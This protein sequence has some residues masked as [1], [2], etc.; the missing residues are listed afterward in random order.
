MS[1]KDK[2]SIPLFKTYQKKIVQN[3]HPAP[4]ILPVHINPGNKDTKNEPPNQIK[5]K[6]YKQLPDISGI[7]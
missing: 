6:Q 7:L 1:R 2:N 5:N 4:V 3:L